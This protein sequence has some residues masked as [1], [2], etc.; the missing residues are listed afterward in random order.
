VNIPQYYKRTPTL[1]VP[2]GP[3]AMGSAGS[4]SRNKV[5][6]G[7]INETVSRRGHF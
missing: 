1:R 2:Y 6:Q 4:V 7:S 5:I 3:V